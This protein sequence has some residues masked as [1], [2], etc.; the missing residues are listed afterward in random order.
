MCV[1]AAL[2]RL[3]WWLMLLIAALAAWVGGRRVGARGDDDGHGDD[4]PACVGGVGGAVSADVRS[5]VVGALRCFRT[6]ASLAGVRRV[7]L[8]GCA[9]PRS[10]GVRVVAGRVVVA[11]MV[12][13]QLGSRRSRCRGC[14]VLGM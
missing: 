10:G 3:L 11:R 5:D 12:A 14:V 1:V 2:R 7:F 6:L 9:E 4:A 13:L 8:T